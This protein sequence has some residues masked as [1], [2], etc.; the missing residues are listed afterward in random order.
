M[1]GKYVLLTIAEDITEL[2][3]A[4]SA[5]LSAQ[6]LESLGTLAGGIAHDFNNLLTGIAGSLSLIERTVAG[7]E[8]LELV[9]EAET[10]CRTA[11]GLARQL[12]TFS[13]GGE[14]LRAPLDLAALVRESVSFSLRGSSVRGEVK[15]PDE[16][17]PVLGD[18]EQL[19]QVVQNLVL[20]GAQAMSGGGNLT[21]S[22]SKVELKA[23]EFADA[24]PGAYARVEVRDS[25]IGI[26]PELL[27][28]LFD[29]YFSTKGGGR[30]LGLAV[31]RSVILKHGGRISVSSEPGKGSAF[32]FCLPLTDRPLA[33]G[34]KAA[35][36]AAVKCGGRV[37]VMDDEEVVYKALRRMLGALGYE[38][39]VAENGEKALAAWAAARAAGRPFTAA[40][41]DLTISGGMGGEK[42]VKLLKAE[43]PAAKVLVSSGYSEDPVMANYASY[44]F[45][46][47]LA[48][49]YQ[50]DDLAAA[51]FKL[52]ALGN[53]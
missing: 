50:V 17:V 6:R 42:A 40:I 41:M 8:A 53:P 10:A 25:G 1:G 4:E 5:V 19:F 16:L 14:P 46:G 39:E 51:L 28:K 49:P 29:P 13:S 18:K 27:P 21:A 37:L 11:K 2:K 24:A 20:N 26:S 45:D 52:A 43:D 31:A 7:G 33:A 3:R 44:G 32:V 34:G 36:C 9:K 12:L 47:V 23:G 30:G 15:A 22:V 35:D 48:K 38:V